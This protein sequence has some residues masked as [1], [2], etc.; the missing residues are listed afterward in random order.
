MPPRKPANLIV[1]NETKNE[2]NQRISGQKAVTSDTRLPTTAPKEL[3]AHKVAKEVWRRLVRED[4]K[5]ESPLMSAQDRDLLVDLCLAS[6]EE[7]Q[8][9]QMRNAAREDWLARRQ[10][11]IEHRRH[12]TRWEEMAETEDDF[13]VNFIELERQ[14]IKLVNHVQAA[15]RTVLDIDARLDGKR[16]LIA[17]YLSQLYLTPKSR[18][19]AVPSIREDQAVEVDPMEALISTPASQFEAIANAKRGEE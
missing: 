7:E 10:A 14:A 13:P 6:E 9:I 15:Y 16:R 17:D 8:I 19:K 2:E 11:A 12:M 5:L 18:A 1:R 4:N 3:R